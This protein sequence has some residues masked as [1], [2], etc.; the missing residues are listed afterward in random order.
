MQNI[1]PWLQDYL[2]TI[3]KQDQQIKLIEVILDKIHPTVRKD[4]NYRYIIKINP[5]DSPMQWVVSLA[6]TVRWL[7]SDSSVT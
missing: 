1:D 3:R 7:S 4:C 5:D 6:A 2:D